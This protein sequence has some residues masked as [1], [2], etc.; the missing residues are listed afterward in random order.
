MNTAWLYS[1][2]ND[3]GVTEPKFKEEYMASVFEDKADQWANLY[4]KAKVFWTGP[5]FPKDDPDYKE[6]MDCESIWEYLWQKAQ[7]WLEEHKDWLEEGSNE[8]EDQ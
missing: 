6:I 8:N 3:Y 4:V 1:L 5:S 7:D 2:F